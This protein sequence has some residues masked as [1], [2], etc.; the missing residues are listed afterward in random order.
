MRR[1]SI[2][3]GL[4]AV[5]AAAF[6]AIRPSSRSAE[7]AYVGEA[8][9]TVWSR[10]AQVREPVAVI[11]YGDRV[12]ILERRKGQALVRTARA[13]QGWLDD[14]SLIGPDLWRR[15]SDILKNSRAMSVQARGRTRVPT[16]V[17][18]EAG[19]AA[20]RVFQYGRDVNV[21]V[22]SRAV[23]PWTPPA[24]EHAPDVREAAAPA[25]TTA[26]SEAAAQEPSK[27]R[28]DDWY[29]VRASVPEAGSVAGWVLARFLEMD[30][31]PPLRDLGAG[32]RFQAWFELNRVLSVDGEKSQYLG[33]GVIGAEGQPCDFTL[34]RVY[35]WNLAR[36]R[37]ETAYVESN[38]C[39]RLPVQVTPAAPPGSGP[40]AA[41]ASFRF[42]AK[43]KHGAELRE[44]TF[45]QNI[46][47]RA[48]PG[49]RR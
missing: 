49:K 21:E 24:L 29:L 26:E 11:R 12:E 46:V 10:L 3:A 37:Y 15:A 42:N 14:R 9:A 32:I 35:T 1:A 33:A 44:Y 48:P 45:R 28:E 18:A 22:L 19:R 8:N 7:A 43:G 31:P 30:Y 6:W 36:N 5:L 34:F 25:P 23:A 41:E 38:L 16:N 20:P 27:P 2:G 39:G 17:R 47:H 40:A 13:E 4:L